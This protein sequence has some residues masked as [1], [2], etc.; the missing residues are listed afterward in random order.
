LNKKSQADPQNSG[1][2]FFMPLFP[3]LGEWRRRRDEGLLAH[4]RNGD[5]VKFILHQNTTGNSGRTGFRAANSHNHS[6]IFNRS[7]QQ[8]ECESAV[9]GG[10]SSLNALEK[11]G[12]ADDSVL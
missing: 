8:L 3:G 2:G 9:L 10:A 4:G 1:L 12:Q 6:R 7:T 5:I 11:R